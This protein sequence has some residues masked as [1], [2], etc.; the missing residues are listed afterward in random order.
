MVKAHRGLAD[1]IKLFYIVDMERTKVRELGKKIGEPVL[2]KGWVHGIRNQG[3]I[4]FLQIRDITG[5]VQCVYYEQDA[6]ILKK[7]GELTLESVVAISGLVKEAK[8]TQAGFEVQ[9]QEIELLSL[10]EA[11]LP[12]PVVEK[13]EGETELPKR[14]DYRWLDLRKPKVAKIFEISTALNRYLREFLQK[15]EFFE[16]ATPKLMTT[17]SE[18]KAELFKV[19]Y[20]E[21]DAY[22]AQSAQYYKQM[23]MA[24]GFEKFCTFADTYRM[25][26]SSTIW[27]VAQF[28]TLDV[29][30]SYIESEEDVF[31]LEEALLKH[32]LG[33][34]KEEYGEEISKSF[35]SFPRY[36]KKFPRITVKEMKAIVEKMGYKP[37][38]PTQVSTRE[39]KLIGEYALKEFDSDFVFLTDFPVCER[40]FYHMKK[41]E[42]LTRSADLIFRGREMSTDAQREH[43][44]DVLVTQV[45]EKGLDQKELQ[46]Y[47]D[48]FRWGCPP[49]GDFGMGTERL[50]MQVLGLPNVRE[51]VMVPRDMKRIKP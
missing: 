37:E 5:I 43:R 15:E 24:A 29:E 1:S 7:V 50:L 26:P 30:V 49:H 12:I 18:S 44:Y 34:L 22:L 4:Q 11:M 6:Q 14:L 47:L 32:T 20:F 16:L 28:V 46:H 41:S 51:A 9:L 8:Q 48:F 38:S 10:A 19:K 40:P 13:T 39:E 21:R 17:P 31:E 3:K 33:R 36:E 45:K 27:H 25:D 23:A 35:G 2:I 42:E